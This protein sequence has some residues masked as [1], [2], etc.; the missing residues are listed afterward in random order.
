MT[1]DQAAIEVWENEG[2][3]LG[4]SAKEDT[5]LAERGKECTFARLSGKDPETGS[6]SV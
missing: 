2:G 1:E 3:N 4:R 6:A 5:V